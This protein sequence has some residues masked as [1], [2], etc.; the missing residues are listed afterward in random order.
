MAG[1]VGLFVWAPVGAH[2]QSRRQVRAS[3][4]SSLAG[5]LAEL[6]VI[7]LSDCERERVATL[8]AS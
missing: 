8:L 5:S 6:L 1:A 3:P 4:V 2:S 7:A